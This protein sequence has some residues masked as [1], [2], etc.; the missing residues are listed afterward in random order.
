MQQS[1]LSADFDQVPD[2]Y[3]F[4]SV[5]VT[6]PVSYGKRRGL[7]A[8][9]R[10]LA[11]IRRFTIPRNS[12]LR[13]ALI[14]QYFRLALDL[15]HKFLRPLRHFET[16]LADLTGHIMFV[17]R[18]EYMPTSVGL[19]C[20]GC[21]SSPDTFLLQYLMEANQPFIFNNWFVK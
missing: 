18:V 4:T 14:F 10:L 1:D 17:A 5:A 16:S 13:S 20:R 2:S 19:E 9:L 15:L 3:G 21:G 8:I 11:R 7:A 6:W 12:S